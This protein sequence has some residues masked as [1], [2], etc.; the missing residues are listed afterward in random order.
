MFTYVPILQSLIVHIDKDDILKKNRK[1]AT[2][3][4]NGHHLYDDPGPP[5][6][7]DVT[8][9]LAARGLGAAAWRGGPGGGG[10]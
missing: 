3:K 2:Q 6:R 9:R 8:R 7:G 4:F 1:K 10:M 5:G